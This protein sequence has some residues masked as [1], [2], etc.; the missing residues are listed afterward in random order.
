M[1]T[2]KDEMKDF[3]LF[4]L[5]NKKRKWTSEN[6]GKNGCS[7]RCHKLY[8]RRPLEAEERARAGRGSPVFARLPSF[9]LFFSDGVFGSENDKGSEERPS[10]FG[11]PGASTLQRADE[12]ARQY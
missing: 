6:S 1:R 3:R 5:S 7:P 4:F 11:L 12:R 10:C 2:V 9:R 8:D